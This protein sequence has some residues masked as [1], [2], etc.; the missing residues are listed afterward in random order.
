M[1]NLSMLLSLMVI[2]AVQVDAAP[3]K[4]EAE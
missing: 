3:S 2:F 4:A 1:K